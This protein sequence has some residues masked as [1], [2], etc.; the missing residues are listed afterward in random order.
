MEIFQCSRVT[1]RTKKPRPE[2]PGRGFLVSKI[3]E[4]ILQANI[5]NTIN[6]NTEIRKTTTYLA[7]QESLLP[8]DTMSQF[9]APVIPEFAAGGCPESRKP[10]MTSF[11][12]WFP[13][14][15]GTLSGSRLASAGGGLGRDDVLLLSTSKGKDFSAEPSA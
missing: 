9:A 3:P 10:T 1:T 13:A 11:G 2:F 8:L 7:P 4:S 5:S 6:S 15:P 14:F 12:V